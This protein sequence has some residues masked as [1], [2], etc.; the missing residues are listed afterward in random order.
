MIFPQKKL[1]KLNWKWIYIKHLHYVNYLISNSVVDPTIWKFDCFVLC[2]PTLMF[3]YFYFLLFICLNWCFCRRRR[4]N[5]VGCCCCCFHINWKWAQ[6]FNRSAS[7]LTPYWSA[8]SENEFK[9]ALGV[10]VRVFYFLFLFLFS[11]V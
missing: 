2:V 6:M 1:K 3:V 8:E 7:L 11:L 5:L 10:C 4:Y 9:V